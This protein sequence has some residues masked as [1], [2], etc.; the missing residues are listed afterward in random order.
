MGGQGKTRRQL[1][2]VTC[3]LPLSLSRCHACCEKDS[4]CTHHVLKFSCA[5]Q[6]YCLQFHYGDCMPTNVPLPMHCSKQGTYMA[7]DYELSYL[8]LCILV[9]LKVF[10]FT[11]TPSKKETQ[12]LLILESCLKATSA[13]S[14]SSVI[15]SPHYNFLNAHTTWHQQQGMRMGRHS[16]LQWFQNS[17]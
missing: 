9:V 15:F 17:S 2:S 1:S 11:S 16:P 10:F 6:V 5:M 7:L 13:G 12:P 4:H 8:P 14:I 3:L